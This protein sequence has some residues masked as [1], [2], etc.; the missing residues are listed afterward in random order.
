MSKHPDLYVIT[1]RIKLA[2]DRRLA[3]QPEILTSGDGPL[4]EA[5]RDSAVRAI[6]QAQP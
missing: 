5:A 6:Y 4:F 1:I 3:D 2:R